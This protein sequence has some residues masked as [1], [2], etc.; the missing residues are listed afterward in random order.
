ILLCSPNNPTGTVYSPEEIQELLAICEDYNIFLVVDET[1]REFVYDGLEPFSVLQLAPGSRR[2]IVVDSLSKR[3]SL[4]GARIGCFVTWNEEVLATTLNIAQARLAA[5]TLEQAASA[6]MLQTVSDEYLSRVRREFEMRRDVLFQALE[7]IPGMMAYKPKGAFY[8]I[9]QLPVDD[10]EKFAMF[11]LSEF[12]LDG[13]TT[14]VAPASG[15]YMQNGR[16]QN[17]VRVAY[18]L[19]SHEL[20]HAVA[21]LRAGLEAYPGRTE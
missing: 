17:K 21:V 2:V 16:G 8:S 5:P 19:E 6:H 3:F 13:K 20:E 12:A 15:F 9:V 4:C 1:Y 11:L 14:F 18:V 10:A 7:Q